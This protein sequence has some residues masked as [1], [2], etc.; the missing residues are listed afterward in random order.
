MASPSPPPMF[1]WSNSS[2]ATIMDLPAELLIAI[3]SYLTT[4]ELGAMRR[5]CKY[6]EQ[7]LFES[8]AKEFFTKRQFMIEHDSLKTLLS[9]ANHPVLSKRLGEVLI[10]T[11]HRGQL[12]SMTDTDMGRF[13]DAQEADREILLASGTARE[14]LQEAF[15]KL[16]H[17]QSVGVRD[18]DGKGRGRDGSYARWRSWGWST[19]R[20]AGLA[21]DKNPSQV[22][23]LVMAALGGSHARPFKVEAILRHSTGLSPNGFYV[24]TST[25]PMLAEAKSLMLDVGQF[26]RQRNLPAYKVHADALRRFLASSSNLETL[27]LNFRNPAG[28]PGA[29][30]ILDW[31]GEPVQSMRAQPTPP[32]LFAKLTQFDIGYAELKSSTLLAVLTKFALTSFSVWNVNFLCANADSRTAPDGC[33][34]FFSDLARLLRP[35]T[36][37]KSVKLGHL[38]QIPLG[39]GNRSSRPISFVLE[40]SKSDDQDCELQGEVKF[41]AR[42]GLSVAQW[43]EGVADRVWDW[44]VPQANSLD[45]SD[46][47]SVLEDDDGDDE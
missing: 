28:R 16:P 34:Q 35:S 40:G 1:D 12:A 9:I 30:T 14:L 38:T 22:F 32:M 29:E 37:V 33:L 42:Y 31:L 24:S 2:M 18:F 47:E 20:S 8:F 6:I 45:S 44:T 27:R 21:L 43:L 36:S 23:A 15:T 41:R 13:V 25:A 11:Q 10:S 46:E 17:L 4:P 39:L 26:L 7:S 5:Y 19:Y 3:S